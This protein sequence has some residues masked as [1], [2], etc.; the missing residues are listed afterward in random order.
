MIPQPSHKARIRREEKNTHSLSGSS[1]VTLHT[2]GSPLYSGS[3][4]QEPRQHYRRAFEA[5]SHTHTKTTMT[6]NPLW[7]D[8]PTHNA[9][10]LV[11]Q[12]EH[13]PSQPCYSPTTVPWHSATPNARSRSDAAPKKNKAAAF[14]QPRT[15]TTLYRVISVAM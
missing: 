6:E 10:P 5:T 13:I 12:P 11:L 14:R 4:R 15:Q 8:I 1:T 7:C 3:S 2:C 9:R